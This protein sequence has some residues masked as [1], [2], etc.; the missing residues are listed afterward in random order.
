MADEGETGVVLAGDGTVLTL[1]SVL[2][3]GVSLSA[4][5]LAGRVISGLVLP[6]SSSSS[7]TPS[8]YPISPRFDGKGPGSVREFISGIVEVLDDEA[9]DAIIF[10]LPADKSEYKSF[11]PGKIVE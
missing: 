1:G 3:A 9:V 8:T 2:V 4:G 11:A 7:S 5:C 10:C 6:V